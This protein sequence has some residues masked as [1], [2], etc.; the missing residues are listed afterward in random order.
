MSK[1][2]SGLFSGTKGSRAAFGSTDYIKP[3][4]NFSNLGTFR[5]FYPQRRKKM[6]CDK[7]GAEMRFKQDGHSI[8]WVCD[9]CGEAVASTYF[10]SYET[11][12]TDYC[13][14]LVAPFKATMDILKLISE[15]ANCN[16]VEAKRIVEKA[17]VEIF[18]GKAVEV[19]AIKE[20]LEAANLEIRIEPEFL[21]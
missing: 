17:P 18:C 9:N 5:T 10:E 2:Y 21:Y 4:D 15:I 12:L 14:L 16:Y 1:G 13:I 3:T 19:K 8:C 6:I 7:C 20:K 11:D